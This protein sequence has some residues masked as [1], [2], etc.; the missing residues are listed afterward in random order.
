[1]KSLCFVLAVLLNFSKLQHMLYM[2][3]TPPGKFLKVLQF[4]P[5]QVLESSG[6]LVI[7]GNSMSRSWKVL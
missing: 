7:S 5:F 1:M 3:L 6:N 4:F 2:V